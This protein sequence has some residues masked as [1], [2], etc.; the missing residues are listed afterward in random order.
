MRYF[1]YPSILTDITDKHLQPHDIFKKYC[2][3]DCKWLEDNDI[4]YQVDV[5]HWPQLPFF[6]D[7]QIAKVRSEFTIVIENV[8]QACMFRLYSGLSEGI[9]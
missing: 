2:E 9:Q 5:F 6:T 1:Q 4:T 7:R 3:D 8:T